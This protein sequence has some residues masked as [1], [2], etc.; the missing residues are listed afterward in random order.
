M[1][2]VLDYPNVPASIGAVISS[3][4]ASLVE[5]QTVLGVRDLYTLLEIIAVDGHNMRALQEAQ[6]RDNS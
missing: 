2:G 3:G 6:K 5:L 4:K 1:R